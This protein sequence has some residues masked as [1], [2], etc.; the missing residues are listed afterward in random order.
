[1]VKELSRSLQHPTEYDWRVLKHLLRYL[2][3]TKH[4]RLY[5]KPDVTLSKDVQEVS[6]ETPVDANWAG[7]FRTRK[8]TSGVIITFL[9][10]VILANAWISGS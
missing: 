7:C 5:L 3:G 1:M 4:Y 9:G 10:A 2:K 8:S 6:L